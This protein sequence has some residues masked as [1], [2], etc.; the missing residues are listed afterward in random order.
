MDGHPD[1][2]TDY[3]KTV[4]HPPP[5]HTHTQT[6]FVGGIIIYAVYANIFSWKNVSSFCI[7][8]N[9]CELDTVLTRAVNILTNELVKL[10]TL[11]TSVPA[12]FW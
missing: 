10:T 12:R 4:Y 7:C 8:K 2:W 3:V 9:T 11:R 1:G 5:T 6:K